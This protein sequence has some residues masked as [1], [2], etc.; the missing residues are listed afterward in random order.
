MRFEGSMIA[1]RLWFVLFRLK[2]PAVEKRFRDLNKRFSF[3]KRLL[4]KRVP[5]WRSLWLWS[6][7]LSWRLGSRRKQGF[8]RRRKNRD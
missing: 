8:K 6:R 3:I 7:G 4:L 5:R 2:L 1:K